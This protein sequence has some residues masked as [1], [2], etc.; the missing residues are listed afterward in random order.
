MLSARPTGSVDISKCFKKMCL[1]FTFS[2]VE[3]VPSRL[4]AHFQCGGFFWR[5]QLS[6]AKQKHWSGSLFQQL[7]LNMFFWCFLFLGCWF[8]LIFFFRGVPSLCRFF[9]LKQHQLKKGSRNEQHYSHS[10]NWCGFVTQFVEILFKRC[11]YLD[12][13]QKC[14]LLPLVPFSCMPFCMVA[15]AECH[16]TAT[17][18]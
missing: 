10:R 13:F 18:S 6:T 3:C 5:I 9:T 14:I 8:F 2:R 4:T 12:F 17:V 1:L 15:M 7:C 11:N 16:V